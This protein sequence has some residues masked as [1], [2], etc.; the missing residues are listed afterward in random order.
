LRR[1]C[2]LSQGWESTNLNSSPFATP[3]LTDTA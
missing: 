1:S 3:P 2:L